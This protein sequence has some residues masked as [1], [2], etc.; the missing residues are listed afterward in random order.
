MFEPRYHLEIHAGHGKRTIAYAQ[1]KLQPR[2][3]PKV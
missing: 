2:A 3:G 1:L